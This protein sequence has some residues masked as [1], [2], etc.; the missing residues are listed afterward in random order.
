MNTEE[1]HIAI[2]VEVNV[3]TFSVHIHPPMKAEL[4]D[5]KIGKLTVSWFLKN[6]QSL[7]SVVFGNSL[8]LHDLD[9][10]SHENL[11]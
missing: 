3:G 5:Q 1:M 8:I 9:D 4:L 2:I 11:C 10:P 6:T 7:K